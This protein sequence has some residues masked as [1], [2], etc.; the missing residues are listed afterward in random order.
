MDLIG[1]YGTAIVIYIL[2]I[3]KSRGNVLIFFTLSKKEPKILYLLYVIDGH[4]L[5]VELLSY[6]G[7]HL[8]CYV[9]L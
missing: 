6:I 5:T 7:S 4:C 1:N 3:N 2:K 8:C 9:V